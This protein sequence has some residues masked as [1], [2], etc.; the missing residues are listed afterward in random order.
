LKLPGLSPL[1]LAG[2]EGDQPEA[3]RLERQALLQTVHSFAE[4]VGTP[5]ADGVDALGWPRALTADF[6]EVVDKLG[7][8]FG[9][10]PPRSSTKVTPFTLSALSRG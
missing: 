4:L 3:Y 6:G 7:A 8:V 2:L 5:L 9:D 10:L 1:K